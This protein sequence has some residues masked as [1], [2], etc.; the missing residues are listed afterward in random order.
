VV[1]GSDA[2]TRLLKR[3]GTTAD[4]NTLTLHY[5]DANI[6]A[7]ELSGHGP[8]VLVVSPPELRDAVRSRLEQTGS[9]HTG[10]YPEDN[11]G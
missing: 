5:A 10:P 4:G 6:L 7:D 1:P 11:R 8:E 9:L 2:A 3:R